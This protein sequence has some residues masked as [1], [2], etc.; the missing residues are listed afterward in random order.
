NPVIAKHLKPDVRDLLSS[1]Q[2]RAGQHGYAEK[3]AS[4]LLKL[5]ESDEGTGGQMIFFKC[6]IMQD[7][8]LQR[9]LNDHHG[10]VIVR[11]IRRR[12]KA[13]EQ[14]CRGDWLRDIDSSCCRVQ[15]LGDGMCHVRSASDPAEIPPRELPGLG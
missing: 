11:A 1:S 15:W 8:L 4:G 10:R 5:L 6:D 9:S 13:K 7:A 2:V 3:E 12:W 14:R